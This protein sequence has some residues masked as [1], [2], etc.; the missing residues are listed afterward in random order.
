MSAT[1]TVLR[2][3]A[4]TTA[5]AAANALRAFAPDDVVVGGPTVLEPD[6]HPLT[7]A[8]FPAVATD[9]QYVDGVTGGNVFVMT[10]AGAW[11][12]AQAMIGGPAA[13]A[14]AVPDRPLDELERSAVGEAMNQMMA[15]AAAATAAVL[16]TAVEISPPRTRDLAAALDAD[17]LYELAP[18]ATA[19]PVSVLGEPAR[20]V[21]LVPSAFVV[22][23]TRALD[24][25][26]AEL[27]AADAAPGVEQRHGVGPAALLDVAVDVWVELGRTRMPAGRMV[28]VPDGGVIPLDRLA[29]DPVDLYAGGAR[30]GRGRLVVV[31]GSEWAIRIESVHGINDPRGTET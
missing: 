20:L 11:R 10:P 29:E 30:I 16:A 31:D 24:E 13:A 14:A 23:M 28:A 8:A 26:G 15:A 3:L 2:E 12:L 7:G 27:P 22:R 17:G 4:A 5:E 1:A 25:R 9:V 18:H 19:V 6:A 21:Q